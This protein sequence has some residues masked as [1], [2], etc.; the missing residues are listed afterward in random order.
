[1]PISDTIGVS[2][3][4]QNEKLYATTKNVGNE[5]LRGNNKLLMVYRSVS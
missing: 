1:M 3:E 4:K 5:F 2:T